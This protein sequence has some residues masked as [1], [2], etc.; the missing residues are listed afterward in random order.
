MA[1]EDTSI[2]LLL[3]QRIMGA[4]KFEQQWNDFLGERK[5]LLAAKITVSLFQKVF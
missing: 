4:R 2:P 1:F 3:L 5:K